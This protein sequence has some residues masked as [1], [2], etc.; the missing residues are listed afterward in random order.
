M[1]K[2]WKIFKD[3]R[4]CLAPINF[5][6]LPFVPQRIFIVSEVP[7]DEVRGMHSHYKTQ[8]VLTCLGGE[9]LIILHDGFNEYKEVLKKNDYVFVDKLVWDSQVYLT[10]KD[11]LLSICS[12]KYD[13]N[14]YIKDFEEF[15]K[16]KQNIKE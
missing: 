15:I 3:K 5:C 13:P 11:V 4:G 6:S 10:G 1:S 8:Q 2:N 16:I 7:K 9:I 14:D 12:T